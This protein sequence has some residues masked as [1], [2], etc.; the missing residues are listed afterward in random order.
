M[1]TTRGQFLQ[2]VA[3][4]TAAL[5]NG[6]FSAAISDPVARQQAVDAYIRSNGLPASIIQT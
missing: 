4:D 3:V 1:T 6:L 2:P 5:L